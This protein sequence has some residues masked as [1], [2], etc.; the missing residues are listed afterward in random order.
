MRKKRT[1]P[2][3]ICGV[4]IAENALANRSHMRAHQRAEV[5]AML[6][7]YA[8]EPGAA[9]YRK[10]L[11]HKVYRF[12]RPYGLDGGQRDA[13]IMCILEEHYAKYLDPD[14]PEWHR[15]SAVILYADDVANIENAITL[16]ND[17]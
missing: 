11:P 15:P 4:P 7:T 6:E 10:S 8:P 12:I 9:V 17:A 5:R 1:S 2:C 14:I 3:R 13:G 16:E